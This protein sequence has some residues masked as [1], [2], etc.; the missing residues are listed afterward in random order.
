MGDEHLT[1]NLRVIER[2]GA[3]ACAGPL[4]FVQWILNKDSV[5]SPEAPTLIKYILIDLACFSVTLLIVSRVISERLVRCSAV[6][7]LGAVSASLL[8]D[9]PFFYKDIPNWRGDNVA[10]LM[11]AA[12]F[13]LLN[14]V[15]A[16]LIMFLIYGAEIVAKANLD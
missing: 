13:V 6:A 9:V 1:R 7:L 8:I 5:G 16:L 10:W 3:V 11:H 2:L 14:G 15:I 12:S 4:A